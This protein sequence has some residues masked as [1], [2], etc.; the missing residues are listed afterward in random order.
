MTKTVLLAGAAALALSGN[1]FAAK[2]AHPVMAGKAAAF[3][4][5]FPAKHPPGTIYSQRDNDNGVGIVSQQFTDFS[6]GTYDAQGADDFI[7]SGKAA[8]K[9][10]VAD[11]TYFNGSG[12][13][14]S[15]NVTVYKDN[16]GIPGNVE[17]TCNST[18]YTDLGFGTPDIKLKNSCSG[19]TS[20]I[21]V[22]AG[23]HWVSVQAVMAF[24]V[25][26]E[27]GW[28]TNNTLRND[29]AVWQNPGNGF[30]TGCTTWGNMQSCLGSYGEG[31]D[32][33]FAVLGKGG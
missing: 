27:W 12:P 25:G 6:G 20:K 9:E 33:S 7:T 2:P 31:P 26:G 14:N 23:H 10:V 15:W 3:H 11:G 8:I 22:K 1:A 24:G 5:T 4:I 17:G 21:K 19:G 30:G 18:H 29:P 13:A 16:G 28:N 32:F